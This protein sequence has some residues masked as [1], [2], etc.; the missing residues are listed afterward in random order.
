MTEEMVNP[1]F[2]KLDNASRS[3]IDFEFEHFFV[4]Q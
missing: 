1:N 4:A 2:A 3:K